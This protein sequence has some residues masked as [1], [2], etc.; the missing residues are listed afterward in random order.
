MSA[1]S[2]YCI[3]Q[4]QLLRAEALCAELME[5]GV[6][7]DEIVIRMAGAFRKS[8]RNDIERVEALKDAN[9]RLAIEI[10][11]DGLYDRLPEG[12]FHQTRGGSNTGTLS[13]MTGEYRRYRDEEK[14]ARKFFQPV[15]QELFRYAVLTETE[16][17]KL[18][19]GMLSGKLDKEFY[20]FWNIDPQLPE[21]P[22][23]VLVL[24]MPW[25]RQI[26]GDLRLT[27][28]ALAMML[29]R[30]VSGASRIVNEPSGDVSGFPL[31]TGDAALS[32]DTICGQCFE[33][34]YEQWVFT[35]EGL[36]PEEMLLYT[37]GKPYGRFLERFEALFIP[38]AVEAQFE[39]VGDQQEEAASEPVLGYGFY[40]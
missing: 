32:V 31:G 3:D 12:L 10:N 4:Y 36:G 6:S 34:P 1:E 18:Q 14:L 17:R 25:I 11:R 26:K 22:A 9:N 35:I 7:F 5:N 30:P 13:A 29:D 8:Y 2:P 40:L 23:A 24:I 39:Y 21:A 15:E 38:L 27:A 33:E 20:R 37:A 19:F 16:E 28:S